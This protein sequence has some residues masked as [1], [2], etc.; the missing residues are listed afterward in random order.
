[1]ALRLRPTGEQAGEFGQLAALWVE[2]LSAPHDA[3]CG[4]GGMAM[5]ILDPADI[6]TDVLDYLIGKYRDA[7][8]LAAF[9]RQRRDHR[10]GVRFEAWLAGLGDA[11]L[12][13]DARARLTADLRI[14][15]ESFAA[16]GRPRV[17]I[18]Y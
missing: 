7:P 17:G 16:R 14:F 4:C 3:A 11:P 6:E 13:S 10:A 2:G 12:N 5:P 18:C 8:E 9:L 1:M 15:L